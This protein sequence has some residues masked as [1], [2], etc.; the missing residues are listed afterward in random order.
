MVNEALINGDIVRWARERSGLT[1]AE[2]ARPLKIQIDQ[3]R[4]WEYG[5][6]YPPFGKAE[7][8]ARLLR[9]PF[10]YLF[11][12]KAPSD[13]SPIPDFRTVS[14]TTPTGLSS[15]FVEVLDHAL[16]QQDW[17][18][19]YQEQD[20]AL[21]LNFVGRSN[22]QSGP[23]A[24]ARD[25]RSYLEIN[26]E[27][28]RGCRDSSAFLTRLSDN[29]QGAGLLVM[30]SGIVGSDTTRP[31]DVEEFRGFALTDPIAPLVFINARDAYSAQVFTLA[32]EIAHIWINQSGIS[33]PDPTDLS[34]H[35]I[36]TFC[37]NVA[38]QV[39]VPS[40]EFNA[41][42]NMLLDEEGFPAK[43]A[44][45]FLV[46]SLVV[47]R[48]AYELNK[49]NDT[50]FFWLVTREKKRIAKVRKSSGGDPM[51]TLLSRNSRRMTKAV[52]NAVRQNRLLYR[53]AAK[54]LGVS[55]TRLP[56]LLRKRID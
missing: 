43:L 27:L 16:L 18:R 5:E 2:V 54:L 50:D 36:E 23:E 49:I 45:T 35:Q 40:S 22:I 46:S 55:N 12:S 19:E 42:W 44:R 9:I 29:A 26:A 33:N 51:R 6:A 3:I 4:S 39:L 28:R 13:D 7:D 53:D 11:L 56:Q 21:R 48:R 10:G 15:D 1:Y 32:H 52:L 47:I 30:R 20:S 38:A 14:D 31:L 25:I 34:A 37:N 17:Y 8:L 41:A 24:V